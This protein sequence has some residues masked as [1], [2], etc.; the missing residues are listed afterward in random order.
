MAGDTWY[1]VQLLLTYPY[2]YSLALVCLH[3][4][5]NNWQFRA[6]FNFAQKSFG[7]MHQHF[8]SLH[9]GKA[10]STSRLHQHANYEPSCRLLCGGQMLLCFDRPA[11][12]SVY[13]FADRIKMG[14]LNFGRVKERQALCSRCVNVRGGDFTLRL[15][16]AEDFLVTVV[17]L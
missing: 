14:V 3:D 1:G 15:A 8:H 7:I 5:M 17:T 10:S 13:T 4:L 16:T 2:C 12:P 9:L 11:V 6:E